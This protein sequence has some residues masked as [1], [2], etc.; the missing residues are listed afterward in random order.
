MTLADGTRITGSLK[1]L[2]DF[3]ISLYDTE[4]TYHS[5]PLEKGVKVQVE[6]NLLFHRQWLASTPTRRCTTSQPT[7]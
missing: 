4:G 6:D 7:W 3:Y 5:I 1:H 2:D